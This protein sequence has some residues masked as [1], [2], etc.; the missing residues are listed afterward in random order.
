MIITHRATILSSPELPASEEK[1]IQIPCGSS[2]H[3]L[4]LSFKETCVLIGLLNSAIRTEMELYG[5]KHRM[6]AIFGGG[7]KA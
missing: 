7:E 2:G 5:D 6:E 3:A 4:H 1:I